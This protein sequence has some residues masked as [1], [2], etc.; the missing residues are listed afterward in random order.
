MFQHH[1]SCPLLSLMCRHPLII[2]VL[3][4]IS[5]GTA[6]VVEHVK[7]IYTMMWM[8]SFVPL[9]CLA[10][11]EDLL[12]IMYTSHKN[13]ILCRVLTLVFYSCSFCGCCLLCGSLLCVSS[14]FISTPSELGPCYSQ[15]TTS[16]GSQGLQWEANSMA[17]Y[18]SVLR[19]S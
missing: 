4:I 13:E 19:Y 15:Y 17:E 7:P 12:F 18:L 3:F 10:L 16:R 6:V 11:S 2:I 14:F 5:A 9:A 1:I 8:Q